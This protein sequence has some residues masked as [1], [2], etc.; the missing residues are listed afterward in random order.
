MAPDAD[1]MTSGGPGARRQQSSGIPNS[2]LVHCVCNCICD[3]SDLSYHIHARPRCCPSQ[4]RNRF[5]ITR[6][7]TERYMVKVF[8]YVINLWVLV[9]SVT[10]FCSI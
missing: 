5:E 2:H 9:G 7:F 4:K 3:N 10:R 8:W 6:E 1:I